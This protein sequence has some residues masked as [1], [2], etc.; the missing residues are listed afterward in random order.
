MIKKLEVSDPTS[1]LNRCRDDEYLFPLLG[2]DVSAPA[3]IREWARDR[4]SR[5]KNFRG[6]E[7]IQGA[8][9]LA[10]MI[11]EQHAGDLLN[12]APLEILDKI[13]VRL[14]NVLINY[15]PRTIRDLIECT[16]AELLCLKNMGKQSLRELEAEL[17]LK[18]L[19]LKGRA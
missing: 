17:G 1:C 4:I 2:R 10:R 11:E 15:G 7:Q 16:P 8:L 3:A 6:D 14:Y 18:G 5:G 19:K 12:R 9:E 13:S